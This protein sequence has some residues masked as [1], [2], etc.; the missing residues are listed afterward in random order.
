MAGKWAITGTSIVMQSG[1]GQFRKRILAP[2]PWHQNPCDVS[3]FQHARPNFR[4]RKGKT[5]L[6]GQNLTFFRGF[7]LPKYKDVFKKFLYGQTSLVID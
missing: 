5:Q 6:L 7:P 3:I 1:G 2:T 4:E